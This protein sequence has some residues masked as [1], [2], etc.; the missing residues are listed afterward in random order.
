MPKL[1]LG[2]VRQAVDQTVVQAAMSVTE[3]WERASALVS[4]ES[5][6]DDGQ[7]ECSYEGELAPFDAMTHELLTAVV[8]V[9]REHGGLTTKL[10]AFRAPPS[11][12]ALAG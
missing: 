7:R 12:L 1:P 4:D 2:E 3:L 6:T 5:A 8:R 11:S 10:M 9:A